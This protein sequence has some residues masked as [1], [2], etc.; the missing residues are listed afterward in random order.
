MKKNA[1]IADV[2]F[3]LETFVAASKLFFST[4]NIKH[5][6]LSVKCTCKCLDTN[7]KPLSMKMYE[8]FPWNYRPLLESSMHE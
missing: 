6:N 2:L 7:F 1:F 8:D 4:E 5:A 3:T